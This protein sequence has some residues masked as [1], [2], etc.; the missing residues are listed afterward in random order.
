L[1][2]ERIEI[3][4]GTD[5]LEKG[6]KYATN[7]AEYKAKSAMTTLTKPWNSSV[8]YDDQEE[9]MRTRENVGFF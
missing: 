9:K 7:Y 2:S 8:E 4:R 3:S 5:K 6:V 1:K